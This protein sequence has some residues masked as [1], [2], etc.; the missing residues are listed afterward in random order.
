MGILN[1]THVSQDSGKNI[2]YESGSKPPIIPSEAQA[3]KP[4]K[5]LLNRYIT[6][7]AAQAEEE[8]MMIELAYPEKRASF[9]N[10][11]AARERE[12]Q[13]LVA[14]HCGMIDPD[15]VQVSR[16]W[17]G[18]EL[19]WKHGSFNMC[20]PVYINSPGLNGARN[21][22]PSKMGFRVPLPY[23][24]G[25]ES[26][27]G[28]AEEKVR[29]EAATYIYINEKCPDVP[30]PKL[31]GFGVTGGFSVSLDVLLFFFFCNVRQSILFCA[32]I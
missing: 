6:L 20:I 3:T 7:S 26:F 8:D 1:N 14:F 28:N 25:E 13:E 21:S 32:N 10:Q 17:K 4:K 23:K 12:I 16:M 2:G 15:L 29:S 9:Y 5:A 27:P 18:N 31:R 22:L 19:V 24:V 11:F 30:I